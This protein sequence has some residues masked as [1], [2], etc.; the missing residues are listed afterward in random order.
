MTI[1]TFWVPEITFRVRTFASSRAHQ[2]S[3]FSTRRLTTQG[4]TVTIVS[5][6]GRGR[7]LN[8]RGRAAR[9]LAFVIGR[10]RFAFAARFT[11][12]LT[13]GCATFPIFTALR[14][15]IRRLRTMVSR[16][17]VRSALPFTSTSRA[18]VTLTVLPKIKTRT[19]RATTSSWCLGC[20]HG[21]TCS[22]TPLILIVVPGSVHV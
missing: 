14:L 20:R 17:R 3:S 6:W 2:G 18:S 11:R 4:L 10:R 8:L 5:L 9:L 16:V 15:L 13:A 19:M 21:F 22:V 12:G 7:R 1:N